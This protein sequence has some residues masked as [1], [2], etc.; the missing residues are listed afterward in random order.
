MK[1]LTVHWQR[2]LDEYGQTCPRCGATDE[3]VTTACKKLKKALA[4]LDIE[5][6]LTKEALDFAT[7]TEDP[8]QSNCIWL[9]GKL[10]EDW[11]GGTIKQSQCCDAG[12]ESECRTVSIGADTYEVIPERLIIRAA[13]LAAA[14]LLAQ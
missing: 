1:T 8:L 3:T 12:G 10:L 6:I 7:F 5:V 2:L 11:L 4:E 9:D 13:L 14:K